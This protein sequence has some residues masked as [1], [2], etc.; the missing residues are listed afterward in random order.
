MEPSKPQKKRKLGAVT[1]FLHV[2]KRFHTSIDGASSLSSGAT[3]DR[4][5][6]IP[7]SE[8]SASSQ[9]AAATISSSTSPIEDRAEAEAVQST[10]DEGITPAEKAWNSFKAILPV[11]E[12][13]SVAFPPLQ[14]AVGGIVGII[15]MF[16][17]RGQCHVKVRTI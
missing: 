3:R 17:V 6:V 8:L 10:V 14:S 9:A 15:S 16:D 11:V 5:R 2:N 7:T 4:Q 1:D 12:K 13:V